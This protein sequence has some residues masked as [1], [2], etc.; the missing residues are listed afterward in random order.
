LASIDVFKG[1]VNL[2][3]QRL[4]LDKY[5]IQ[6]AVVV[7]QGKLMVRVCAQVYNTM[8]DFIRLGDAVLDLTQ[9][10]NDITCYSDLNR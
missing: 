5:D 7:I 4:I 10:E 1:K 2:G 9:Q 3:L 8:D 6:V